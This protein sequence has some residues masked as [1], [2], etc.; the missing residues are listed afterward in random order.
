MS[1]RNERFTMGN[2]LENNFPLIF[3]DN[4]IDIKKFGVL[5]I[6]GDDEKCLHKIGFDITPQ[7]LMIRHA[8]DFIISNTVNGNQ[9]VYFLDVKFSNAPLWST[10]RLSLFREKTKDFSLSTDRIGVIA[11]EALLVYRRY[12][13]NTI[14]V[15]A[16]PYNHN[17]LLAQFAK[18]I[19]CIYCYKKNNSNG[20]DCDNCPMKK[21]EFFDEDKNFASFGSKMPTTNIDL[22]SFMP[23]E[24]FFNK[25]GIKINNEA[26]NELKE[27]IKKEGIV[28]EGNVEE[29]IKI[30][31]KKRLR[32]AG[33]DW[34]K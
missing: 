14:I 25:I 30:G 9:T 4:S 15:M 32:S 11:R 31:T 24:D 22:N 28:F 34:I 19:K 33:C 29:Y 20:Y 10:K 8:P 1:T 12:Y 26:E 17:V 13:P 21:G 23:L 18:K 6:L 3:A 2:I 16:C 5:T 7:G 27:R